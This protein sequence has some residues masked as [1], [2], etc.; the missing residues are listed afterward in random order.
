MVRDADTAMYRA[1]ELGK[2]RCEVFD[3]SMLAAAEERLQLESDL[4]RALERHELHVY[5]QPIV[6]LAER[7]GSPASRRCCAGII[8]SAAS[9][10]PAQFIPT[11]EETGL[12]VPI[13]LWVLREAC[14]QLQRWDQEFPECAT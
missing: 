13:G 8:R 9:S 7:H 1:K 12:I 10:R 5:Y 4:R 6:S 14:R 2:A 3:T 11:A